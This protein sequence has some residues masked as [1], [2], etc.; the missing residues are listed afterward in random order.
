MS[1]YLTIATVTATL[2]RMV[3]EALESV[4]NPSGIPQVR[5]GPPQADPQYVGCSIFLCRVTPNAA[6]RNEDL[7]TRDDSGNFTQRPRLML[8]AD[9]LL[10]FSGDESTLESQRFLGSVAIAL[11]ARPFVAS[12]AVKKTISGTSF[13]RGSDYDFESLVRITP[14]NLDYHLM[15]QIWSVFPQVQYS[16]SMLYTASCI[17]VDADVTTVPQQ[18][19][20]EVDPQVSVR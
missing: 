13:L 4:P 12:D 7:P 14:A 5:Y 20:R 1:N 17:P 16:V 3:S 9:Y 11:H 10:S 19:V 6:R 8:D 18:L 15:S 2:G